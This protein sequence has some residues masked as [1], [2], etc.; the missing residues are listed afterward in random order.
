MIRLS[1]SLYFEGLF[2]NFFSCPRSY[3][4][5]LRHFGNLLVDL[6]ESLKVNYVTILKLLLQVSP[7]HVLFIFELI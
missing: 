4:R 2:L 3:N 7:H 6:S 5:I 1:C